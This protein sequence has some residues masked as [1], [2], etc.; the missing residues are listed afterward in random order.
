MVEPTPSL[1]VDRSQI[2]VYR[3]AVGALDERLPSGR[4]SLRRAAWAGLQD[5]MPRAAI[6]SIHARVRGTS[7]GVLDDPSLSQVWGPGYSAYVVAERDAALFT[8][9]R[10][11]EGTDK[12]RRAEKAAARLADLLGPGTMPYGEAG[13]ALGVQPNSLRYASLTGRVRIDWDGARQPTIRIVPA[14][15]IEPADARR[16]LARRYLHVFGP[17][18]SEGFASWA[19][20]PRAQAA[21]TFERLRRSLTPVDTP[22]GLGSMLNRDVE[23]LL[24]RPGAAAFA[25]LLP[26]GDTYWLLHGP[27]RAVLVPNTDHRDRL[28]TPRVWPGAILSRGEIVGTWRRSRE[29]VTLERWQRLDRVTQAAIEEEA[30]SLPLPGLDREITVAWS[31]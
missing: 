19:G 22:I 26:S 24:A 14:P 20:I 9:G 30:A 7:P 11:V 3:R 2:L 1:R 17:A 5:S 31:D 4:R 28:W 21:V 8:L 16:E 25:R 6:L 18:T 15:E 27:D 23:T 13:R 12:H 29:R 10:L